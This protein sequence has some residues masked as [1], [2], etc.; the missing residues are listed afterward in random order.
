MRF[1][2]WLFV[3]SG[4]FVIGCTD[5][6][7]ADGADNDASTDTGTDTGT[8]ADSDSDSDTDTDTDTNT[9]TDADADADS[10]TDTYADAGDDG[11]NTDRG[12]CGCRA[13]GQATSGGF[14]TIVRLIVSIF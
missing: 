4:I 9:A 10:D 7:D 14:P 1:S 12:S 5:D 8:D 2:L 11:S 3:I 6:D 13:A